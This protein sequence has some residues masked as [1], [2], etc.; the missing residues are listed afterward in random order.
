MSSKMGEQLS[1]LNGEINTDWLYSQNVTEQLLCLKSIRKKLSLNNPDI[2]GVLKL[3]V[4]QRILDLMMTR[5]D[6]EAQIEC[7]W[8]LTNLASGK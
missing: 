3:N 6:S 8:I 1:T 5:E 2:V 7:G 4:L